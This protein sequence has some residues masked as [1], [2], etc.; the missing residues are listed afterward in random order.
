MTLVWCAGNAF[1][2]IPGISPN[3]L[4]TSIPIPTTR[5]LVTGMIVVA[6]G[7]SGPFWPTL[8]TALYPE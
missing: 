6:L 2:D 7:L 1:G 3:A 8:T 4:R 5:I